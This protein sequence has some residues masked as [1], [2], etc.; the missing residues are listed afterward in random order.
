MLFIS[1][2][3]LISS[4]NVICNQNFI[5]NEIGIMLNKDQEVRRELIDSGMDSIEMQERVSEVDSK[6]EDRISLIIRECS[7]PMFTGI[8][9][10]DASNLMTV[11]SHSSIEMKER[12]LS[13]VRNWKKNRVITSDQYAIFYDK[14]LLITEGHQWYGTQVDITADGVALLPV[15]EESQLESRRNGIG[16]MS[17]EEYLILIEEFYMK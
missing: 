16:I 8:S 17:L 12:F 2:F 3:I 7:L 6:N 11:I 13:T 4:G 14:F 9:S 1:F 10:H 15:A 5:S